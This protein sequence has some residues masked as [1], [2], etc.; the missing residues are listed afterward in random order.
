MNPTK[1]KYSRSVLA[2]TRTTAQQ[3]ADFLHVVVIIIIGSP[4][5]A[6]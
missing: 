2:L 3:G 1:P 5:V 6:A 4:Q